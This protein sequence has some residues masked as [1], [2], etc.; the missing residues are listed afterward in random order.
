[1]VGSKSRSSLRVCVCHPEVHTL[2]HNTNF[3]YLKQMLFIYTKVRSQS[4]VLPS[5][6]QLALLTESLI[7][8]S[9][10]TNPLPSAFWVESFT[11]LLWSVVSWVAQLLWIPRNVRSFSWPQRLGFGL[12]LTANIS[13]F[14]WLLINTHAANFQL[15][16][17]F[18]VLPSPLWTPAA[19]HTCTCSFAPSIFLHFLGKGCA[20]L[21]EQTHQEEG[22]QT[23]FICAAQQLLLFR[24]ICDIPHELETKQFRSFTHGHTWYTP[25][26]QQREGPLTRVWLQ[27]W[28]CFVRLS[29]APHPKCKAAYQHSFG[30][31]MFTDIR[32]IRLPK[33]HASCGLP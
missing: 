22:Q 26:A 32:S 1:M 24:I 30:K 5:R 11:F 20:L 3:Q 2:R 28:Q 7:N 17:A 21:P 23:D 13:S 18:P 9:S 16:W 33:R 31:K 4:Q 10:Q 27:C 19:S 6:T 12:H 29:W 25:R 8:K 15:F 14:L